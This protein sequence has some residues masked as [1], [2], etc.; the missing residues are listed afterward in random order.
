M[1]PV[2]AV[3]SS[4]RFRPTCIHSPE[5]LVSP[6]WQRGLSARA[7]HEVAG[8]VIATGPEVPASLRVGAR[9]GPGWFSESCMVCDLCMHGDHNLCQTAEQTIVSTA[10]DLPVELSDISR[11]TQGSQRG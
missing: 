6:S 9:I 8:R 11:L 5:G 10:L 3:I 2:E 4:P 7:G 1:A